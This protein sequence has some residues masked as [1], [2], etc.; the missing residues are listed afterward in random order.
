LKRTTVAGGLTVRTAT[1]SDAGAI[2][3]LAN[4]RSEQLYCEADVS[5]EE[6]GRWFVYPELEIRVAEI[7]GRVVG[8]LDVERAEGGRVPMD[9]RVHPDAW[10]SGVAA[11]LIRSA[12]EWAREHAA[13]GD[14]LRAFAYE[15][16]DFLRRALE[17]GGYRFIRY[18]F[19][20]GVTLADELPPPEWPQGTE[21]RAFRNEDEPAVYE[22][23]TEAFRDAWDFQPVP[24]GHW[25]QRSLER[26][27][28]DPALWLIAWDGDEVAGFSLNGW[29]ISGDP[30]RGWVGSLG[31]RRPWRRRGLASA[32]LRASFSE[33][34][35]GS[36][37][38]WSRR[39]CREPDGSGAPL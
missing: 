15:H 18:F 39:R 10:Q 13:E 7:E 21:V 16:E 2:A 17:R 36:D 9:V 31:V 25:R 24:R 37:P 1:E 14:L 5:A 6:V 30:T 20:M 33:F 29:D 22:A 28:F 4:A 32:L 3:A 11:A 23:F 35:A 12:E 27:D 38:C 19:L 26:D 8:Y 34:G